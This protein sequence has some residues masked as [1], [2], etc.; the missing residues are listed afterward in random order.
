MK[1][2]RL[3]GKNNQTISPLPPIFEVSIELCEETM[4]QV[5]AL[6]LGYIDEFDDSGSFIHPSYHKCLA[7]LI[8]E[9]AIWIPGYIL[10][11]S[12]PDSKINPIYK[13]IRLL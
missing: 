5:H 2:Q 1:Q 9:E 7:L 13:S 10:S 3:T 6:Q 12:A 11:E 4:P 8:E